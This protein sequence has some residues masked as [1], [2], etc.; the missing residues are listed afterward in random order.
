M[1]QVNAFPQSAG[2]GFGISVSEVFH[3]K[4]QDQASPVLISRDIPCSMGT[5]CRYINVQY[6]YMYLYVIVCKFINAQRMRTRVAVVCLSVC[7]LTPAYD[8][9]NKLSIHVPA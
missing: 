9:C 5:L 3:S 7:T 2:N 4:T 6:M 1:K 8:M